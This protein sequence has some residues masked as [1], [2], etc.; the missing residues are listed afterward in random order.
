MKNLPK[1]DPLAKYWALDEDIVYLNHGSFGATPTSVLKVQKQIRKE[2]EAE[3][4]EFYTKTLADYIN[5]SK[6]TLAGFVGTH[7]NNIV[8]V[9]N[10]T[11]GVNTVLNCFKAEVGDEWLITNHNYGACIH[12]MKHYARKRKCFISMADIPYPVF[13]KEAILNAI[14][15]KIKPN[16]TI[17][18]IDFIS[19][20]TAIIFPVK[21]IIAMLHAKGIK[22]IVD[23]A[24]APGMVDFNLD[25]LG[26]D[27]FVGNCH[28]W[29]C[30]PKGSA[31]LYVAPQHQS[32]VCPLII[33]HYNDTDE[34]TAR[35]WSN[36]FLF[37][38]T[39]DYSPYIC[40]KDAL[41][42]MPSL[43]KGDWGDVRKRNHDLVWQAANNIANT[44]GVKLPC[45]EEM[46]GS[47]CNIPMPPGKAPE[48]KFNTNTKLKDLLFQKYKIEVPVF[49][50]PEEPHQWLRISA[51]LYNSMEQYE[52][53]ADCLKKNLRY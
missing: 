7:T 2:C 49:I 12:A 23:A 5:A 11:A 10:A 18:L 19:S 48:K 9:P 8:F 47:I 34:G 39:Q 52:Y 25:E 27:F 41:K 46:V 14:E 26:A 35:H 37:S 29:V 36:Q 3:A 21:E 32:K 50:F 45:N 28:K 33:S 40:V 43:I 42:F 31:F 51:Q 20:A 24:H 17:A 38:G 13:T 15:E 6:K 53:L 44:L 4:I 22:V 30:S 16:T 1:Y